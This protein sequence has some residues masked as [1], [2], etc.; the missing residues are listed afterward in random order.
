M[1]K[2]FWLGVLAAAFYGH[3]RFVFSEP[4]VMSW[5]QKQNQM[6][7][8][9]EDGMCDTYASDLRFETRV[10]TARG[11]MQMAGDKE[12]LCE[13]LKT[14]SATYRAT[15]ASV[16]TNLE[17]VSIEP[18]GFPWMSATVN[19]RQSTTVR[20]RGAP[21]LNEVGESSILVRRT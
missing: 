9:G 21:A 3:S 1:R 17:L 10:Q 14:A 20:M 18:S 4:S 5:M 7:M 15:Q 13:L 8:R 16:D 6:A 2:L 19:V 12:E 11:E